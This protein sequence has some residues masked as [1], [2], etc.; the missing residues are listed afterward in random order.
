MLVQPVLADG[1][2][3]VKFLTTGLMNLIQ[4]PIQR[5]LML[6]KSGPFYASNVSSEQM[7]FPMLLTASPEDPKP[8]VV[9]KI[10]LAGLLVH[11]LLITFSTLESDYA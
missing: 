10:S 4:Y 1:Q 3:P 11:E 9:K 8:S 5:R 7:V 6:E 2:M